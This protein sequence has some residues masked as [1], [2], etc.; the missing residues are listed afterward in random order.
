MSY[1]ADKFSNESSFKDRTTSVS[2]HESVAV[3]AARNKFYG[4]RPPDVRPLLSEDPD[5]GE[6]GSGTDAKLSLKVRRMI[7]PSEP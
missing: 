7:G 1:N 2:P 4:K 3:Q 6:P 5:G